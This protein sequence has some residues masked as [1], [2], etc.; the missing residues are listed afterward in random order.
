MGVNKT[1]KI[2]V[3]YD[4]LR[5][6]IP[7]GRISEYLGVHRRTIIRW[8]QQ[9]HQ[10]GNLETFLDQ[11]V[12]AKKG[13]RSKRKLHPIIKQKIYHLREHHTDCCGQKIQYFL[14]QEGIY[15]SVRTIYK[16]LGERYQLRSKWKKHQKR[17]MI[18]KAKAPREVV[19]MDSI[20]FGGVFAFTG[21]DICTREADVV[22]RPRLT[23][24]DGRLFLEQCMHRRFGGFSEVIQTDGGSEFKAE[25]REGVHKYCTRHRYA[26]AYKKNEQAYIESFNRSV[27]KECLGWLKYDQG[28]IPKLTKQLEE[29]LVY[30]HYERP[31]MGLNMRPPLTTKV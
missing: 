18:P 7:K 21:V 5:Q 15:L 14:Q 30:Y 1:T 2:A 10:A 17:G 31:H 3:A 27:R 28:Q 4:L 29:W 25:F 6:D 19:Q 26:R 23:A 20:D 12:V 8:E 22:L 16:V 24:Q 9:I 13:T 11:Y